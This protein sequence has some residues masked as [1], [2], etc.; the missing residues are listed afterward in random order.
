MA[1]STENLQLQGV[2]GF[3]GQ[4]PNGLILHPLDV[5][6]IYPLGSSIVVKHLTENTQ[7]F[8]REGGHDQDV[9]CLAL[10]STGK[11]LA[12]GQ[13][14]CN[15][16]KA[17]VIVWDLETYEKVHTLELHTGKVQDLAFSPDERYLATLGGRDD[18]KLV[19]WDVETGEPICGSSASTETGLVVKWF[20][21]RSDMLVT[22]GTYNL[23]VWKFHA[24]TRKMKP[25]DVELGSLQRIFRTILVDDDDTRMF[26]G[27]DTGDIITVSLKE[28]TYKFK[29][30]GPSKMPF[31][32]GV[33]CL[34]KQTGGNLIV[35]AG[36]G[37]VAV[38]TPD[39]RVLRKE[40]LA[41]AVTSLA[42]NAAEDHFF[43][44]TDKCNKYCVAISDLQYDLRSTCHFSRVND[45][46]FP[47]EYSDLFATC[48]ENDI[49]IWHK[50]TRNELL[51]VTVPGLTCNC[52][53]FT[54]DGKSILSGWS[55][56]KIRAF[57]PRTGKL[58]YAIND[59][60]RDG[61]TAIAC[62]DNNRII[63]GGTSGQ[64][65]VW[66]LS[67]CQTKT[68]GHMVASMKEH[69]SSITSININ[70]DGTECVSASKDGSCIV[71]D[72]K[73]FARQQILFAATK[74][75]SCI[76]HPDQAQ[77]LTAG[78]DRKITYWDAVNDDAGSS[79][80]LIRIV[81]G[82]EDETVN[83]LDI[84]KSGEAFVSGGADKLVKVWGY[85]EG[86]AY[87]E[88]VGHS[89]EVTKVKISPNQDTIVSVGTEGAIFL[90]TMPVLEVPGENESV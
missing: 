62:S 20:N 31:Q 11:Y 41:G 36:D 30:I 47:R 5:H 24:Q 27:T 34:T 79:A 15:G 14:A 86:H 3:N 40:K 72:L 33:K 59:A 50:K 45:V 32:R 42:I 46:A 88:G 44:G 82:S 8:L 60:H 67:I 54:P 66:K 43:V 69:R 48:G 23:R 87:V 77:L 80:P 78:S 4:T 57:K 18:N 74:F 2:I 22:G 64:V 6:C 55:D 83:S 35:G 25:T 81:E 68:V 52:V 85:D 63:S 16:F 90:W 53:G 56:G 29:T 37:T 1:R 89:G 65:R 13:V 84:S 21:N 76:Y 39:F 28:D 9:S 19:I 58:H 73:R 17:P 71:W 38:V 61:V 75:Q 51:R 7:T 26:V 12:T 70:I 49:R 10:S